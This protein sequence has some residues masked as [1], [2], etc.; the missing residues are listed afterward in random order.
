MFPKTRLFLTTYVDDFLLSGPAEHHAS[1]WAALGDVKARG[2]EIEDVG[3]LSRFL[4][5][6]Y[7]VVITEDGLEAVAFNM[8][9]HVNRPVSATL[10]SKGSSH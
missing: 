4:G 5:R 6:H 10:P 9:D 3:D 2:I 8:Q 7:D 1:L